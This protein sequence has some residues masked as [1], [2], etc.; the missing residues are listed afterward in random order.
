MDFTGESSSRDIGKQFNWHLV[1]LAGGL[2]VALVAGAIAGA[3][4]RDTLAGTASPARP[5]GSPSEAPAPE[6][7]SVPDAPVMT[8]ILVG[9]QQ[10]ANLLQPAMSAYVT[11]LPALA[12]QEAM[13]GIVAIETAEDQRKFDTALATSS[14]ELMAAGIGLAV[15]DL[16]KNDALAPPTVYIVG[17]QSE[18]ELLEAAMSAGHA[19][20]SI[21]FIEKGTLHGDNVYNT[22]VGDQMDL[23]TFDLIDLRD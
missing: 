18:K 19:N 14:G 9:S 12:D 21:F 3:F 15:I 11:A 1:M 20:A 13:L 17:S 2:V 23:G 8:Y 10:H 7:A 5:A 22:I 6:T 16:R 4:D